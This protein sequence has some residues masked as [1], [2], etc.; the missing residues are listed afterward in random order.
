MRLKSELYSKEQ[1]EIKNKLYN[2]LNL[3]ENNSFTLYELDNNIILQ[4]EILNLIPEIKLYFKIAYIEGVCKQDKIKRPYLSIIKQL[5]K[6][7]YDIY[8]TEFKFVLDNKNLRTKKY[9]F[10]LKK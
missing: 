3:E 7:K 1:Q 10:I 9:I 8:S 6:E 4:Q 5:A 2:I